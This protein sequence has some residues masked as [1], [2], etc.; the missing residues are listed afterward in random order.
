MTD[1]QQEQYALLEQYTQ[2]LGA[3]SLSVQ[4]HVLLLTYLNRLELTG[5]NR[6]YGLHLLRHI[7]FN[8]LDFDHIDDLADEYAEIVTQ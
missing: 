8:G 2:Q 1:L 4:A 7:S 3:D 6:G 5:M